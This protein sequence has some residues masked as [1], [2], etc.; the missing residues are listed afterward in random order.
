MIADEE[1]EV[2]TPADANGK[3]QL[4]STTPGGLLSS[5]KNPSHLQSSE[6][7]GSGRIMELVDKS[8]TN[9]ENNEVKEWVT[10]F[11]DNDKKEV[12]DTEDSELHTIYLPNIGII[13]ADAISEV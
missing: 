1:N 12:K 13:R 7:E 9:G 6:Q 3:K 4:F 8:N 10:D 5:S 2:T 11:N